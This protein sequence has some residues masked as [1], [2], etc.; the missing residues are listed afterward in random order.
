[1]ECRIIMVTGGQRSGKS[2]FAEAMALGL[3]ENPVYLATSA[4][5]DDKEFQ[6]R[7]RIHQQR[8]GPRWT[9]VE[10]PLHVGSAAPDRSVVLVDCVTLWA[11]NVFFSSGED[12]GGALAV[13]SAEIDELKRKSSTFIFVT[14]EIGLG[15]ISENSLQ[16]R[17]TDLQG[18]VN[19]LIASLADEVYLIVSGIPVKIK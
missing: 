16:R 17:F 1:M 11:T 4:V 6:E 10:E 2:E 3:A 9:T 13:I 8:R 5:A 12:V 19:Q 7:V 18:R 14:N 15:G